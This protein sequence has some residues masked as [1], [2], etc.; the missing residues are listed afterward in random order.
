MCLG[1]FAITVVIMLCN[2]CIIF[3]YIYFSLSSFVALWFYKQVIGV[4]VVKNYEIVKLL[5][6]EMCLNNENVKSQQIEEYLH[7]RVRCF[8]IK[9]C[10]S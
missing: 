7:G 5:C 3:V 9:C 6:P 4:S 10:S 8:C 1:C 2:S